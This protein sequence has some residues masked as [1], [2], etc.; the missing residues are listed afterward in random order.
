MSSFN[1]SI[2]LNRIRKHMDYDF[3]DV[4]GVVIKPN[5]SSL[6]DYLSTIDKNEFAPVLGEKVLTICPLL[7]EDMIE[8]LIGLLQ[9]F[10]DMFSANLCLRNF[11][12]N[13]IIVVNGSVPKISQHAV[14]VEL[15]EGYMN[16]NVMWLGQVIEKTIFADCDL[17]GE[18]EDFLELFRADGAKKFDLIIVHPTLVHIC[19][20]ID[21]VCNT[22]DF[23]LKFIKKLDN[24]AYEDIINTLEF[25]ADWET[26]IDSNTHL[27]K[28]YG[29]REVRRQK[30]RV[31]PGQQAAV[32]AIVQPC[33]GQIA[34]S[35]APATS[36]VHPTKG[37]VHVAP[38]NQAVSNSGTPHAAADHQGVSNS[39]R[40]LPKRNSTP[41]SN[42]G[43]NPPKRNSN[44]QPVWKEK[45]KQVQ[46][47]T[48]VPSMSRRASMS[49]Q[50]G[51]LVQGQPSR[52]GKAPLTAYAKLPNV[53]PS[54]QQASSSKQQQAS[55]SLQQQASSSKSSKKKKY[56]LPGTKAPE[57]VMKYYRNSGRHGA[58]E[59]VKNQQV[60]YGVKALNIMLLYHFQKLLCS[61]LKGIHRKNYL[62]RME[63]LPRILR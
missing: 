8:L 9:I 37:S 7:S 25:P 40:N 32:T 33:Q 39:G 62:S 19:F 31:Q 17:L 46:P 4:Y 21:Y 29:N 22:H 57:E 44:S 59:S 61:A 5:K 58:D 34:P 36:I 27:T 60:Q 23:L 20:K 24:L 54:Q 55:S 52:K 56:N 28:C 11:D 1:I 6:V 45:V 43:R 42:S 41:V 48:C 3:C 38:D 35:Q 53:H 18:T 26:D 49:K 13:H 16:Q 51:Q 63:S 30:S 47:A 14:F 10:K 15:T 2:A 50:Q 12:E